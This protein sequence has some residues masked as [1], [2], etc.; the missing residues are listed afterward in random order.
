LLAYGTWIKQQAKV[1][2]GKVTVVIGRDARI[3]GPM[4]H[5]LVMNTLF[6]PVLLVLRPIQ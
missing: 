2:S 6:L 5:N 4:I 3:S 1:E